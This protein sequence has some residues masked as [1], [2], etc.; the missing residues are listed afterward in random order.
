LTERYIPKLALIGFGNVGQ[1][2]VSILRE[3]KPFPFALV[4]VSDP[5]KGSLADPEGL[6]PEA[7][8]DAVA[9]SGRIDSLAA[10]FRGWDPKRT[11][12]ESGA[13]VVVEMSPTDLR[14][15]EPAASHLRL[16]IEKGMDAITTN[17]GPVALHYQEL[18]EE[19]RA[20]DVILGI[21]GTVMSGTPVLALGRDLLR[22]SGIERISGI[23]NGT[24]N[25]ILGRMEAGASY[26]DALA[27]AQRMGYAEADPRADVEGH[28]ASA[29]VA[30]LA[31]HVLNAEL[32]PQ[33]VEREGIA[34]I[35][36]EDVESA[37]ASGE[38][39]KLL[40]RLEIANGV[41]RASVRPT[42]L[43]LHHPL[44]SVGGAAN[45]ITFA[46]GI[47]GDVTV[48]G[49]GAGRKE[50]GYAVVSDLL[51]ILRARRGARP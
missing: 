2:L 45:A 23:L 28:D 13:N 16:A 12:A 1:G 32:R 11:I 37:R 14:T 33:D 10:P 6:D 20:R 38:R 22:T 27:E 42:R 35:R 21:E 5:V 51:S 17:K 8:L 49:P 3:R 25:F 36:R 34:G 31:S 4:A 43:A 15:G 46:T 44:A 47:L 39:I 29:K 26:G 30:I 9:G 40:G 7:L 48:V 50:T 41:V 24:T 18:F 19:A